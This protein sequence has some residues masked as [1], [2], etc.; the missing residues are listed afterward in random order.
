MINKIALNT[1]FSIFTLIAQMQNSL[2][3]EE[4]EIILQQKSN[5]TNVTTLNA[6]IIEIATQNNI[7]KNNLSQNTATSQ[8]FN[9]SG[10]D[11]NKIY[12]SGDIIRIGGKVFKANWWTTGINP[13]QNYGAG[14]PWALIEDKSTASL[15]IN[16]WTTGKI[17]TKGDV[18]SE[19][20]KLYMAK[21]WT[22]NNQPSK[23][24]DANGPWELIQSI[25]DGAD[26]TVSDAI[27]YDSNKTFQK[28]AVI[29]IEEDRQIYNTITKAYDTT[30]YRTYYEANSDISQNASN[31]INPKT[32]N[33]GANNPWT[34]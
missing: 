13:E 30:K 8:I 9:A 21:W 19:N 23:Q 32:N 27:L 5:F 29:Y 25:K 24:T 18:I 14:E 12:L 10:F 17:Y 4:N 28:G 26:V 15:A 3:A 6:P 2:I 34:L 1:F 31:V 22:Q 20:N 16:S 33:R 11:A 7:I